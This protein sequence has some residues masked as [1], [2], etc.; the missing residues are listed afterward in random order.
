MKENG[1]KKI[2]KSKHNRFSLRN[3]KYGTLPLDIQTNVTF[4]LTARLQDY[5]GILVTFW[6]FIKRLMLQ[7]NE[8][9]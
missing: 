2:H 3:H 4:Q 7:A 8:E 5:V 6:K 1:E 9:V